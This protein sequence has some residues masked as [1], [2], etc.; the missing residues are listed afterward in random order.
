MAKPANFN[1]QWISNTQAKYIEPLRIT[2]VSR[3]LNK[4]FARTEKLISGEQTC[5][6]SLSDSGTK[7]VAVWELYS[8]K[9]EYKSKVVQ[10][11][12]FSLSEL[13]LRLINAKQVIKE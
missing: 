2:S 11:T 13:E 7:E 1:T 12:R 5:N 8:C 6:H 10:L 9:L 4:A 3:P